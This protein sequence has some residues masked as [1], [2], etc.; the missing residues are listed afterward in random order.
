MQG[1]YYI[2]YIFFYTW[3]KF[4]SLSNLNAYQFQAVLEFDLFLLLCAF[5]A[6]PTQRTQPFSAYSD[7]LECQSQNTEVNA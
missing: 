3:T 7:L 4:T 1:F 6:I 5:L 2:Y